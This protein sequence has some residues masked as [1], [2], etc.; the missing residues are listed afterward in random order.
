M[1]G[2]DG[3]IEPA[4]SGELTVTVSPEEHCEAGESAESVTL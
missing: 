2:E 4:E 1:A 3:E